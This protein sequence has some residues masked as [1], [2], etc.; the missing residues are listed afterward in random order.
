MLHELSI[1][2]AGVYSRLHVHMALVVDAVVVAAAVEVVFAGWY[3]LCY[4]RHT[5]HANRRPDS[6]VGRQYPG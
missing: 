1:H 5:I 3:Q 2:A 4:Y 6:G